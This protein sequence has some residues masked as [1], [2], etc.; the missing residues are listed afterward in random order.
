MEQPWQSAHLES[1]AQRPVSTAIRILAEISSLSVIP[2]HPRTA[3]RLLA[4][5]TF[6]SATQVGIGVKPHI[7]NPLTPVQ[8]PNSAEQSRYTPTAVLWRW[9]RRTNLPFSLTRERRTCLYGTLPGA[10][11]NRPICKARLHII[12]LNLVARS[13]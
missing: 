8:A 13:L 4:R 3:P 7:S 1:P 11:A 2:T 10:G 9:A 5:S 12:L 6:I